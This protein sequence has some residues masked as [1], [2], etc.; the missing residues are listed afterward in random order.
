MHKCNFLI[1]VLE[2]EKLEKKLFE[3]LLQ[4]QI[5]IKGLKIV[6]WI[7]KQKTKVIFRT[8]IT[9]FVANNE[10]LIFIYSVDRCPDRCP[11]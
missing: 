5:W 7:A 2:P 8:E 11:D 9:A 1:L 3:D 6:V 10:N 4:N